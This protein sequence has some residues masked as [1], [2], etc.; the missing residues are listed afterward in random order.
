MGH[1]HEPDAGFDGG[2]LDCGN[3]LLLLIRKHIDPLLPG[4]L[5][6][7]LSSEPTVTEELPAWC[8]LTG[9][10][11]VS[12]EARRERTSYLV[13]K[14]P[15]VRQTASAAR[16]DK[17][18]APMP[19]ATVEV[20]I[21][22]QLPVPVAAAAIA[23]MA[24]MG[25]GSWPRPRW[26]LSALHEHLE[27]RMSDAEF[28][29]V[30]DDAVRLAVEAQLRAGVDLVTDGEQRRDNYSSFVGGLLDNCQLVPVTDLLPYVDDPEEF[31][32][33]LRA[34]DV[35][36]GKVRHPAVFGPLGRSRPLAVHEVEF[37]RALCD[38]PAKASL[39]G[40]YLLTRTMWMECI[41]DRAYDNRED[42]A[43][44]VVRVL[45]EE[46]FA[47]LAAGTALVQFDEPVLSEVAYGAAAGGGR[48]FMCGA[49]GEKGATGDELAFA[50]ELLAAVFEGAP[51]DRIALH[52]CRGNWSPDESVAL[53][54]DY[55]PLLG[56]LSRVPVGA[57]VLEMCT[58]RAGDVELLK[59]LPDDRRVGVGVVNQKTPEVESVDEIEARI[60]TAFD[61]F[62]AERLLLHPDCGFATFADNPICTSAIAEA[63][64]TNTV[65]ARNRV[66]P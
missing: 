22:S 42:L 5:L 12:T 23:P 30:A 53:T 31:E 57:L 15:F 19:S 43:R 24:V 4:Q 39:P 62:G 48:T 51:R 47:L 25:V 11:L 20:V 50:E 14:G 54:G 64:L 63:K 41:S 6:E 28:A 13:S 65:L 34:L 21:P 33:E 46:L 44:D 10:E 59:A 17:V 32:R 58:P 1:R 2:D 55:R 66:A 16:P 27:G 29:E 40:P 3:G 38:R 52:V 49:L 7:I 18:P 26:L 37:A 8:R 9:N 61:L 45:R 35:P 56:L 36:A 60:R